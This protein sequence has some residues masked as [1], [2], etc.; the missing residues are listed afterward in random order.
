MENT[1]PPLCSTFN[2]KI[3]IKHIVVH[4]P[5]FTNARNEFHISDNLYEANGPFSDV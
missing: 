1:K 5:N 4:Y 3:T 2:T